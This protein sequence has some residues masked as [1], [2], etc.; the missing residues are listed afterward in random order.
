MYNMPSDQFIDEIMSWTRK[1]GLTIKGA[2][3]NAVAHAYVPQVR[4]TSHSPSK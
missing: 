4:F 1:Q 3:A 2:S